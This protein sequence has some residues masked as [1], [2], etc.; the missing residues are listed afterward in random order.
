VRRSGKTTSH[1][2]NAAGTRLRRATA[3]ISA[4]ALTLGGL[5][6]SSA[7]P[8]FAFDGTTY[9]TPITAAADFVTGFPTTSTPAGD[10]G[11]LGMI[12]DGEN[13]FVSDPVGGRLYKFPVTGGDAGDPSV[14]VTTGGVLTGLALWDGVY[15]GTS[16]KSI[17]TFDPNTLA[18]TDTAIVL[19]CTTEG[20]IG[21]PLTS[22]LFVSTSCGVYRVQDPMSSSPAVTEFSSVT[23]YFDGIAITSDGQEIWATDPAHDEVLAFNRSGAV[24]QT[25]ADTHGPDG[26]SLVSANV[27]AGGI[28]L[29]NN[30]FINNNDGTLLRVDTNSM[31]AVSIVASGGSR[32]DFSTVGPDGC[33]YATQSDRIVKFAP[34]IFLRTSPVVGGGIDCSLTAPVALSTQPGDR[35]ATVSWAPSNSTPAGCVAGSVVTPLIGGVAQSAVLIP[36]PG[37]T[38]V[39][40]GLTNGQSYTFT[41]AAEDSQAV[42]EPSQPIGPITVGAPAAVGAVKASRVSRGT[43]KITFGT[44][45]G[46]GAPVTRYAAVCAS[47]NGGVTRTT[48]GS[49]SPLVAKVL[50]PG[51]TYRCTVRATNSRGTGPASSPSASTRA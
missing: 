18:V 42:G 34:C 3:V 39:V 23:D 30:V 29:S 2:L 24:V 10:L 32:G 48:V 16:A 21:D 5:L 37:T 19:P 31:N 47:T 13:F 22:D 17:R 35:S 41:V 1:G 8:A 51:K 7:T 33:L 50:T 28:D 20:L 49:R 11:P 44:P 9:S 4:T 6:V 46:N 40:S 36:G 38:T 26:I 45:S 14:P 25:I 15:F 27:V 43:V 12:N